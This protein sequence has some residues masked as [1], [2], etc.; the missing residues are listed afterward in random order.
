MAIR[1]PWDEHEE[2]ILLQTLISVLNNATKRKHAITDVSNQLRLLA[3]NQGKE[4]DSKFRNENGIA[5]QMSKLEYVFTNGKSGLGVKTGWYFDIVRLYKE[6]R[7]RYNKLLEEVKE[8][9]DLEKA[10]GGFNNWLI[11]NK[12]VDAIN[13]KFTINAL[14]ILLLKNRTISCNLLQIDD[15]EEIDNLTARMR[16][17]NGI[18][19][20][21]KR[22]RKNYLTALNAY[23]AYLEYLKAKESND[24]VTPGTPEDTEMGLDD[25]SIGNNDTNLHVSFTRTHTYRYTRPSN[26]KYFDEDYVVKNWTQTYVQ[27]VKC[28]LED[29]PDIIRSLMNA[30]LGRRGRVDISDSAGVGAMIAP[31]EISEQLFLETNKSADDIVNKLRRFMD[32]CE[33]DYENVVITYSTSMLSSREHD[34]TLIS[35]EEISSSSSTANVSFYDWLTESQGMSVATGRSYVSAIKTADEYVREYNI[36]HGKIHGTA[37]FVVVRET[38]G[39]LFE[40]ADF[41]ELNQRQHNR[42]RAALKKYLQ[43]H[44][45]VNSESIATEEVFEP[46][47][48]ILSVCFP[49]GFRISSRLDMGRFRAY[50]A[51]KYGADLEIDDDTVRKYISHITIRYQDFVYL[52]EAMLDESMTECLMNYISSCFK[53][54]KMAVYFDAIYK[55][56][57]VDFAGTR[58]NNSNML[59]TYLAYINDGRFYI[60]RNYLT[61]EADVEAN[62]TD[63]VRDY[64]ITAGVPVIVEDLKRALSHI[65][66]DKINWVVAGSNSAEFVRNQKGEYIHADIISFSQPETDIIIKLIQHAIDD[67]DYMSGKELTDAIEVKLP[68]IKERYPFLLRL[69]LRGSIAY[70]LRDVFCFKGNIISAYGQ[71]LSMSDVFAHFASSHEHFTLEQLNSLRRDL[72]TTIYFDSVYA[73]SLRINKDEFVSRHRVAFDVVATDAAMDR[74]CTGDYIALKEI[75]FFGSFPDAGFPWNGFLLEHYVS[76]FSKKYELMHI[77]FTAGTPVG[78]IVKRSSHYKD[79][80]ELIT[81]VLANSNIQLDRQNALQYL[82]D[83]GMIARKNYRGIEQIL[84]KAKQQRMQ[85]G[86][87]NPCTHTSMM[88]N[89]EAYC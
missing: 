16:N 18:N 55:E 33:V 19:I 60:H 63:E 1:V 31:K 49:K 57:Q 4:I 21:S 23:K 26:L 61:A 41:I 89:R 5:L 78:A 74:F 13:L 37:D 71:D 52:P 38:V 44:I 24:G 53:E 47:K 36:G 79:F 77:G 43:Y 56:F 40:T 70:K 62:P 64:L 84:T 67:K 34:S 6:E 15:V 85:K 28:L 87:F 75:S 30:S 51:K 27:V 22:Q 7:N 58:I 59:K 3:V 68:T 20:Y 11:E 42:F 2:V 81:A 82:V 10:K 50:W 54:G 9:L 83:I 25:I 65:D 35:T 46:Y 29:Y 17:N 32:I 39:A 8:M 69:G 80:T 45:G 88:N 76:D 48:Q 66:E 72:D 12:P 73:N 86:I 14:S